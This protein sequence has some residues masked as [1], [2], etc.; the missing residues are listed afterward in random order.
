MEALTTQVNE[1]LDELGHLSRIIDSAPNGMILVNA[2]GFIQLVNRQVES[3]FGYQREELL[4]KSVDILLPE[5]A[6]AIHSGKRAGYRGDPA[7]RAMAGRELLGQRKDGSDF[8]VEVGLNPMPTEAGT[9][10]LSSV[11]DITQRKLAQAQIQE[12]ARLKSEFLANMS[13]EI[14][15]PMNVIMGMSNLILETDLPTAQRNYAEMIASGAESLLTI[16]NDILDFSKIEAGKLEIA[17][18]EFDLTATVEDAAGFLAEAA[19]RK[20]LELTCE[21]LPQP[22][23]LRGDPMRIR[24]VLINIIGNAVKFT[25]HGEVNVTVR[26]EPEASL[27]EVRD[28]GIGMNEKTRTG[29]F[30]AFFQGD[31]SQT[32]QYGGTGLGLAI[33]KKLVELMGGAIG[34]ESEP[35]N[36]STFRFM[37]PLKLAIGGA[38]LAPAPPEDLHGCRALVIDDNATSRGILAA[39]LGPLVEV[40]T[41]RDASEG[42]ALL[43][44]AKHDVAIVD[45]GM[46]AIDGLQLVRLLRA[47]RALSALPIVLLTSYGG[48]RSCDEARQLGIEHYLIKPVP[49]RQLRDAL[50]RILTVPR[51]PAPADQIKPALNPRSNHPRLL[52]V[53]DNAGNQCVVESLLSRLGYGCDTVENGQEAVR[54]LQKQNYSLVFMDLQMPLMDGLEATVAIR[55]SEGSTRRTR[56]VAMTANAML[57]DRER[58]LAAGM[59][60]YLSKPFRPHQL[61]DVLQ[62]WLVEEVSSL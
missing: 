58:C 42:L 29:L 5:R 44:A 14:R 43:R 15:T 56:I 32:R 48:Y 62:R 9:W 20:K 24:Q 22:P 52:V 55:Q 28:T 30:Q 59:D 37:L 3:M 53:E 7:P 39:Q 1:R 19:G 60:D 47:D 41:A 2:D 26:W 35:G 25:N 16:L 8:P 38:T 40:T 10:V 27:F 33:S 18:M 12:S 57:G 13:H 61:R 50:V 51:R 45:C 34:V 31:G 36:G 17:E 23:I 46:P 4:G 6:R 21:V 54:A 11:V 49:C